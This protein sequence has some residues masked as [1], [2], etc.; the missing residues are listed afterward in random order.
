MNQNKV[1]WYNEYYKDG[2]MLMEEMGSRV[3]AN[4]FCAHH[5]LKDLFLGDKIF[6][7]LAKLNNNKVAFNQYMKAELYKAMYKSKL[8]QFTNVDDFDDFEFASR[9]LTYGNT[10]ILF[11]SLPDARVPGDCY[12]VAV[13]R[14][15]KKLDYYIL[16]AAL[17][18][19]KYIYLVNQILSDGSMILHNKIQNPDEERFIT[20]IQK[21]I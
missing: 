18:N 4:Y 11:I 10:M 14:S 9:M 21:L 15:D 13:K 3:S 1:F 7:D 16:E 6:K 17:N 12:C 2:V 20:I 5:V 19:N 8:E